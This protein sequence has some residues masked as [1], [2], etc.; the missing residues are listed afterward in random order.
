MCEFDAIS[1][2]FY[3]TNVT[4]NSF[5]LRSRTNRWKVLGQRHEMQ[6]RVGNITVF[7]S[8]YFKKKAAL[9]GSINREIK[10]L[11][12]DKTGRVSNFAHLSKR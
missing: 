7:F 6:D 3:K 5:W 4:E 10:T 11:A 12:C 8:H 2:V 1:V 9:Q